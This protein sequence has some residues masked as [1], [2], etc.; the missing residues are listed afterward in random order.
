MADDASM[1]MVSEDSGGYDTDGMQEPQDLVA[2]KWPAG[3]I[4]KPETELETKIY[5]VLKLSPLAIMDLQ[6]WERN[7][8]ESKRSAK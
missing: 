7:V 2:P 1:I 8:A 3:L 6:S 4:I 5:L